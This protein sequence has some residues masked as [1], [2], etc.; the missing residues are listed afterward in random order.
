MA[1]TPTYLNLYW[2]TSETGFNRTQKNFRLEFSQLRQQK[3]HF[4]LCNMRCET[5][6]AHTSSLHQRGNLL[7]L[8]PV[9][10][11][12]KSG[13]IHISIDSLS[14]T[15]TL[16]C[17][18]QTDL[19]TLTRRY[20]TH[21]IRRSGGKQQRTTRYPAMNNNPVRSQNVGVPVFFL[22]RIR[23]LHTFCCCCCCCC[24]N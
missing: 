11:S 17:C 24:C 6:R 22:H 12:I 9:A 10:F 7:L 1:I 5:E 23:T 19:R 15:L 2:K 3:L 4:V 8:R 21:R 16:H 13:C 14:V 18:Q 20:V